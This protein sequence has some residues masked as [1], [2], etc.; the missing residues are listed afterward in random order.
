MD[1]TEDEIKEAIAGGRIAAITLDT[2]I[3]DGNGNRFEHG[4]LA[5]LRQFNGTAIHVVLSDVVV[6]EVK[7]HV[8]REAAE[9][10]AKIRANLKEVAKSWQVNQEQR[11]TVTAALFG[12]E[13][14]EQLA[15]RRF[16]A[17]TAATSLRTVESEGRVNITRVLEAYFSAKPPFGRSISKKSEFPD[18]LALQAL[19]CWAKVEGILVLAVSKDGDWQRYCKDSPHLVASDDLAKSLSYFH[20][21]AEVACARLVA[22]FNNGDLL[23]EEAIRDAV[24][25]AADQWTFIPNVSSGYFFDANVY[26]VEVAEVSIHVEEG[27]KSLFKVIDKPEENVLV[28]EAEAEILINVSSSFQ[29]SVTDPIDNDE[30]PIGSAYVTT[31]IS[32]D[33]TALL[34]F[35]GDLSQDAE[36]VEVEVEMG[37]RNIEVD[38]GEVGPDWD[39]EPDD[40]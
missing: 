10:Q 24:C 16:A 33:I 34:T 1:L 12:G 31:G 39:P 30:V 40:E 7:G 37:S 38:Y 14:P 8:A 26:D 27:A 29:F 4:L 3:F 28:V 19:E 23:V 17:F 21:N 5:R 32:M 20:Q 22:R 13:S 2:S 9:A 15:E 36:L 35:E 6:G 18:A 25:R 11:N